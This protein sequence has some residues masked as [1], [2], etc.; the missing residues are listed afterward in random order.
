MS[1]L[2]QQAGAFVFDLFRLPVTVLDSAE[3]RAEF[4]GEHP[5]HAAQEYLQPAALDRLLGSLAE[6]ELL[7]LTDMFQIRFIFCLVGGVPLAL[8]PYCCEQLTEEDTAILFRRLRLKGLPIHDFL[9]YRSRFPVL[10]QSRAEEVLRVL[11]KNVQTEDIVYT[12][13]SLDLRAAAPTGEGSAPRLPYTE[14]VRQR[15]T[16]EMRFMDNIE[17]GNRY[18]AT[19]NWKKMHG[20]VAHMKRL[21]RTLDNARVAAAITRTTMRIAAMHAG[22]PAVV[23]DRISGESAGII[24][25]ADTIEQIDREHERLIR[26]YC[27]IIREYQSSGRSA[28]VLSACYSIDRQYM[29]ELSVTGLA[30][31]LEVTPGYLI[32]RFRREMGETPHAYLCR[33]RMRQA[34]RLLEQTAL[35]VQTVSERVGVLDANY[36]VKL[37]KRQYGQ[38]P[39]A[40]RRTH[41]V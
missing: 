21:G 12:V 27:K 23:N 25:A 38:T 22:I 28:L 37:F 3:R 36:F 13:R 4:C 10:P 17:K 40:Y 18:A 2:I 41:A 32:E 8:G 16:E 34:A 33:V 1:L 31:E 26:E 11:I 14:L 19:E 39:T 6:R 20:M 29:H 15:Y 9:I 35:P 30:A 24:R 5:F 7:C